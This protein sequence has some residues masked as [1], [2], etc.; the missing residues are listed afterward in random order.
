MTE[1]SF[2][3]VELLNRPEP[4]FPEG[5]QWPRSGWQGRI[6]W[7]ILAALLGGGF[8]AAVCTEMVVT[9]PVTGSVV[10]TKGQAQE[11][12]LL[13]E[14]P[15]G[16][17]IRAGQPVR[18]KVGKR[19]GWGLIVETQNAND[20][21]EQHFVRVSVEI[22]GPEELRRSLPGESCQ[23]RVLV[24]FTSILSGLWYLAIDQQPRPSRIDLE[25]LRDRIPKHLRQAALRPSAG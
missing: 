5:R 4:H 7:L 19:N 10:G 18:L 15:A 13:A 17:H 6:L 11:A 16:E 25:G 14:A 24:G 12:V 3:G 22:I 23:A 2:Q 1:G 9:V 8:V 21:L 20:E